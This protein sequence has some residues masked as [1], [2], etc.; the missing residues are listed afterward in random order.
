MLKLEKFDG[1][2]TYM[3]PNGSL[4]TPEVIRTKFP[5]I[6]T[7][8]HVLEVNGDICQAVINLNALR[9]MHGIADTL[10]EAEAIAA[11]E[12]IINTPAP[13]PAPTAEERIAAQ[14]EYQ[15]LLTL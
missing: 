12:T 5:A 9:Q 3:F 10:T 14:M 4:A 8:V 1:I 11:I 6:D 15:N 2:K 13:E 7:F